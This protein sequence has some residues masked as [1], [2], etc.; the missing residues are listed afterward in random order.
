MIKAVLFDYGGVLTEGG[1]AGCMQRLFGAIYGVD[2][3]QIDD[4]L[5]ILTR[6]QLG[7]ITEEEFFSEMNRR[8]QGGQRANRHNYIAYADI[9]KKSEPVYNLAERL[10]HNRITTAILSNIN[11]IAADELR[12]RGFY[13]SFDPVIL[14]YQE[15]LAKP[16]QRF[17]QIAIDRLRLRP[18]EI[19]FIDDQ[20]KNRQPAEALGL[21][22]ILANSPKQIVHDV[23]ALIYEEND[24]KL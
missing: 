20:T 4:D 21:H 18:E 16:D 1:K 24:I 19:L 3:R 11:N 23:E 7:A 22:F 8:H 10:R 13:D 6:A 17:Y 2:P 15:K 12:A 9:F 14:S 5:N